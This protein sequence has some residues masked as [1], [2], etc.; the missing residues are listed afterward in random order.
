M[1][2][3]KLAIA[4]MIVTACAIMDPVY[5]FVDSVASPKAADLRTYHLVS[6]RRGITKKNPLYR[7]LSGYAH[8]ALQEA[9]FQPAASVDA[10]EVIVALTYGLERQ[11]DGN[12]IQTSSFVKLTGFDWFAVRETGAR[13][14]LWTT[15]AYRFGAAGGIDQAVPKLL[16]YAAPHIGT[17]TGDIIEIQIN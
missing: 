8:R 2:L 16:R 4:V 10:A 7:E 3:P 6:G 12:R 5:I 15:Q 11:R 9:G 17:T 14:A 1:R 13:N